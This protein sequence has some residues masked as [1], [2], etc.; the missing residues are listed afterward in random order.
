MGFKRLCGTGLPGDHVSAGAL[1]RL[2]SLPSAGLLPQPGSSGRL[3]PR[4]SCPWSGCGSCSMG[5]MAPVSQG[6]ALVPPWCPV[7]RGR[8]IEGTHRGAEGSWCLGLL[9][10]GRPCLPFRCRP[11]RCRVGP[12]VGQGGGCTTWRVRAVAA[13]PHLCGVP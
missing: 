1:A 8:E 5:P 9:L 10:P 7:G 12:A 4:A 13:H 11:P 3:P 6:E 2:V